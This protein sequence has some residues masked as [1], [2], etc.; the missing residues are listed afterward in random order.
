M[1][2]YTYNK[3]G[4]IYSRICRYGYTI[5]QVDIIDFT[6]IRHLNRLERHIIRRLYVYSTRINT[7]H[8]CL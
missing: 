3:M 1:N 5:N 8:N 6:W 7:Y 2:K 4:K